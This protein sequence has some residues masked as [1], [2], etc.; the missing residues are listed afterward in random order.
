MAVRDAFSAGSDRTGRERTVRAVRRHSTSVRVLR[1]L[2]PVL[3]VLLIVGIIANIV[4]DPRVLLASKVDSEK[5]G[6]SGSKIIMER[7]R[8]TG[9]GLNNPDSS[10]PYE[11]TAERAEQ[12]IATPHEF[13]LFSLK[14]RFGMR[15]NGWAELRAETGHMNNTTQ[16]LDLTRKIEIENDLNDR[17]ELT[18]AHVDFAKNEMS[19]SEPVKLVFS[20]GTLTADTMHLYGAGERAVFTGRVSMILH[21]E[22]GA[23]APMTDRQTAP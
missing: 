6:V 12:N 7:P 23:S 17:A 4:L 2:L 15:E 16:I 21:P 3:A 18:Q 5:V 1:K 8:L 22:N 11:I 19:S 10:Q 14:A 9:Y 13:D 20:S